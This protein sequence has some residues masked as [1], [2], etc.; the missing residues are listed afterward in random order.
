MEIPE[1]IKEQNKRL[2]EWAE[3]KAKRG[4]RL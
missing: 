2:K 1:W 3:E 4:R